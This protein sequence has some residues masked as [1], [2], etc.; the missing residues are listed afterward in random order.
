MV[1]NVFP[2]VG[3]AFAVLMCEAVFEGLFARRMLPQLKRIVGSVATPSQW[4]M[5]TAKVS[6][7]FDDARTLLVLRIAVFAVAVVFLGLGIYN[8]G[9]HS[10]LIKAINICSE[11]IG[12]G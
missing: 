5:G 10:V 11:C 3:A 9:A 6:A 4:Q 1:A 2:W 7:F 12:L 8:G